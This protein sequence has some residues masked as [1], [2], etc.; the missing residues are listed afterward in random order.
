MGALF[1]PRLAVNLWSRPEGQGH[2]L[3]HGD[4]SLVPAQTGT[5]DLSP[6]PTPN[7][8]EGPVPVSHRTLV[9]ALT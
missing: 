1:E 2:G 5:R 6:R 8:D 7:R 9:P 4:R 3:G